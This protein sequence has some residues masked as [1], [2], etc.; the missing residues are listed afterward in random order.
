MKE[1]A[2]GGGKLQGM[3]AILSLLLIHLIHSLKYH[4]LS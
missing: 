3:I 4:S 1:K 2:K